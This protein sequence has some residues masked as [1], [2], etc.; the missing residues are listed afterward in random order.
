MSTLSPIRPVTL[1]RDGVLCRSG[2]LRPSRPRVLVQS[3]KL[4]FPNEDGVKHV[5]H[6]SWRPALNDPSTDP[7]QDGIY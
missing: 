6:L 3:I 1:E 4:H 5:Q 2:D 7:W